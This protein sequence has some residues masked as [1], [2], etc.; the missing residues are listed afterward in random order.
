MIQNKKLERGQALVLIVLSV[1][2]LLSL[3]A[4]TVDG[5]NAYLQKRAVQNAADSAALGG[6]L[7]RV[8]SGSAWVS[9]TYKIAA[10]N[11]YNND[12]VTNVVEVYSP[13]ISGPHAGDIEYIQVRITAHT[14]TYF[15]GIVGIP[16]ITTA[17][18]AVTRTK[19]PE[20]TQI[21]EG[22]AVISLAPTSDCT[23]DNKRSFEVSGESTL[24]V[25][26]GGVFV[27]SNNP[28]CALKTYG[29]GSIRL[30][31]GYYIS[32]VGGASIQKPQLIT[33]YP[34]KTGAA[35]ISYPPPFLLP[36]VSCNQEATISDDGTSMTAGYWDEDFPPEGVTG[37]QPGVYCINDN[38]RIGG[39][40][41]LEG[42]GVLIMVEHG[43]IHI[44]GS[45]TVQLSAPP[46]GQYKGLLI[47]MPIDNHHTMALNGNSQS[48]FTGTIL[49]PGAEIRLKGN[50]SGWGFRSQ[51]IGYRIISDG[52][53]NIV[54]D[55][56]DPLN[57][58][59]LTMPEI[60]FT[61]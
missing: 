12:G 16:E 46:F 21:L 50:A 31:S 24:D 43:D 44:D 45:A 35:P 55:Y 47:Y 26:G 32:V 4:L 18:E 6:A 56:R 39:G 23:N 33:P 3:T 34:I 9:T 59:A 53:S 15:A 5:G 13:P 54:I 19:T 2:G 38:F 11:G 42:N 57:Y 30:E 49:A 48:R 52:N 17:A 29:S 41:T 27:N 37:L 10:K 28:T 7:A 20:I 22:N 60:Q 25:K 14:P 8:R 36:K 40:K 58:D 51:I 1:I 61:Q